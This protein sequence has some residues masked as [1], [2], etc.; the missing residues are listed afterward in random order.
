MY[1]AA[2]NRLKREVAIKVLPER[3]RTSEERLKRFRREAEAAASLKHPNIAT[4]YS[5]EE[6]DDQLLITMEH[7]EGHT[8]K[9]A[10][11]DGGMELE[12]FFETFI[13][14]ADALAHAHAQGRVHRDLKPANIM[15]TDDGTPKILDFGLARIIDPDPVEAYSDTGL[16]E[17]DLT[18][19]MREQD[20]VPSLTQGGQLVGT[21]QYMSPEQAERKDTDGRTDIFSL[22]LVMYEALTGQ[23][24]FDGDSL[25]SIIGR[26]LEAEPTAITELRPI[27]PFTLWTVVRRCIAKKPGR[28]MQAAE[29]LVAELEAIRQDVDGGTVLVDAKT[30]SDLEPAGPESVPLW[31]R[32][33]SVAAM[34]VL[35]LAVGLAAA[36]AFRPSSAP[37]LRKFQWEEEGL[38]SPVIS[39]DGTMIVY[40]VDDNLWVRDL[41][42]TEPRELPD[43]QGA[44]APFWSPGSDYVGFFVPGELRKSSIHGRSSIL[45][46]E[47]PP[48]IRRWATWRSDGTIFFQMNT[49]QTRGVFRISD[50]GGSPER[51]AVA[52]TLRDET[53]IGTPH[54]LP[55]GKSLAYGVMKS[56]G[57]YELIIQSGSTRRVVSRDNSEM[58]LF[59][60]YDRSGYILYQRGWPASKGIWAISFNL[61]NLSVNG[62]P[63]PVAQDVSHLS[64]SVDGTLV[65]RNA[66]NSTSSEAAA[67]LVWVDRGGQVQAPIGSPR[68][69]LGT[70]TLSPDG[71]RVAVRW[72][73]QG[74][75]DIWVLDTVRGTSLRIT[76]DPREDLQPTWSPDGEVVFTTTRRDRGDVFSRVGDASRPVRPLIAEPLDQSGASWSADGRYLAYYVVD[77]ETKRD[78]WYRPAGVDQVSVPFLQSPHEELLP[79]ISPDGRFIAYQ[80]DESGRYEVYAQRFPSGRGKW[81]IS[82]N[83]GR[84]PRWNSRGTELFYVEP[85][86]NSLM[87][88]GTD[89]DF[90]QPQT[91]FTAD[92]IGLQISSTDFT[93]RLYDVSPDGQRFV[94]VKSLNDDDEKLTI[95]VVENWTREFEDR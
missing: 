50:Q 69:H 52:D 68:E 59:P 29:Q 40:V 54:A 74:N 56:D 2:D 89:P 90:G 37:A 84:A 79:M 49:G 43:T 51:W 81:I 44:A 45:L 93:A 36:W 94:A 12:Q 95:T 85:E 91:L 15:I 30:L 46:S 10:I 55:D 5:L 26:I 11:P 27:T 32:P 80:S 18:R 61:S 38:R 22:G 6:I 58:L 41:D 7:V 35:A 76:T 23:R 4:I 62:K 21:P 9:E 47:L 60:T 24:A 64:V 88:V 67:Q 83:G 87:A 34:I 77:P 31:Q 57:T 25:E 66:T 13:A 53:W 17:D 73:E 8:L 19:T 75:R 86:T 39:P 1:L 92:D 28:R 20:G 70:P 14:L 78:L 65:Y 3:L 33:V 16:G 72:E 63:F 48:T 82:R 42:N 71:R